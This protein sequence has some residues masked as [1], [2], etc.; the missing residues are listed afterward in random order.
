MMEKGNAAVSFFFFFFVTEL[1]TDWR[2]ELSFESIVRVV[3]LELTYTFSP[4]DISEQISDNVQLFQM[5]MSDCIK[6]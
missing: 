3:F 5:L 2:K 4:R 6:F 1:T